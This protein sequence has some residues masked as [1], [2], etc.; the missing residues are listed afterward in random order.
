M[1][2]PYIGEH[3]NFLK[4]LPLLLNSQNS[5]AIPGKYVFEVKNPPKHPAIY[6]N[7]FLSHPIGSSFL[8]DKEGS[9]EHCTKTGI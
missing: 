3:T 4:K 1:N 6:V 7:T 8:Q 2:T 5:H 9:G